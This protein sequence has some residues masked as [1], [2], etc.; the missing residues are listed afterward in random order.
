MCE[1]F[2][3]MEDMLL[4]YEDVYQ[5]PL[6]QNQIQNHPLHQHLHLHGILIIQL[7][8]LSVQDVRKLGV[9][10][11]LKTLLQLQTVQQMKN[12]N[13]VQHFR[14]MELPKHLHVQQRIPEV[15]QRVRILVLL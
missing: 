9:E 8:Q 13:T 12:I 10:I 5:S 14:L 3:H 6:H 2:H 11:Q 1:K 4:L 15:K 7:Q